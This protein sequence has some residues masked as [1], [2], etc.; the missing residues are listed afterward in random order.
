MKTTAI[1]HIN[2]SVFNIAGNKN[3]LEMKTIW[4]LVETGNIPILLYSA[5]TW[6]ITQKRNRTAT[7]NAGQH[8]KK[9]TLNTTNLTTPRE[10]L[11]L[12]RNM[13]YRIHDT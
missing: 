8:N 3:Q 12:E 9:D 4:K 10:I 7:Q 6:T 2:W 11:Q 13:G 5:E 1:F